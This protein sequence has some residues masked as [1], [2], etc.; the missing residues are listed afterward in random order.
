MPLPKCESGAGGGSPDVFDVGTAHG[1]MTFGPEPAEGMRMSVKWAQNH[2]G[3]Q[4]NVPLPAQASGAGGGIPTLSHV[5][6]IP[7]GLG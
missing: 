2:A 4:W 6:S 1:Y 7:L 5:R 3:R